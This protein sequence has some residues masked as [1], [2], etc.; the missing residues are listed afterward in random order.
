MARPPDEIIDPVEQDESD[1]RAPADRQWPR[2]WMSDFLRALAVIPEASSAARAAGVGRATVYTW[3]DRDPD[4]AAAWR[5][6]LDRAQDGVIRI[7]HSWITTGVPIRKRTTKT[8]RRQNADGAMEVVSEETVESESAERSA[9]LMI[10]WL[11][12][13]HPDRFRWSERFEHTGA[14][15]GPLRVETV[16]EIEA[17]IAALTAEMESRSRQGIGVEAPPGE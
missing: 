15:G 8:V 13:Y 4:F 9:T 12:A 16:D 6:C 5:E 7:A 10:F 11:K 2:P 1:L 3:R 17:E 14:E